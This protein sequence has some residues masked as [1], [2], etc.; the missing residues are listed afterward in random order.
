[1]FEYHENIAFIVAKQNTQ[2]MATNVEIAA[3]SSLF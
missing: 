1:L 3:I 2:Q